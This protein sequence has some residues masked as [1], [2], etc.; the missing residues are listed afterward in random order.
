MELLD[1]GNEQVLTAKLRFMRSFT[2]ELHHEFQDLQEFKAKS[3]FFE[4]IDLVLKRLPFNI[5]YLKL[6]TKYFAFLMGKFHKFGHF[7]L[8]D[9]F[10]P[11]SECRTTCS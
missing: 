6:E 3:D 5:S 11:L 7:S 9:R 4:N 2:I 10:N 1:H 8:T